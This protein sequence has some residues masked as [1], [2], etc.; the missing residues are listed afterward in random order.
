MIVNL[1]SSLPYLFL[2]VNVQ[3]KI[4]TT[5]YDLN[6]DPY[7]TENV[8]D[9]PAY[10]D[11]LVQI[12]SRV[13]YWW[14]LAAPSQ[15]PDDSN[16]DEMWKNRGG[17]GPWLE[18]GDIIK[19]SVEKRVALPGTDFPNIVFVML[20]DWGWNDL[21]MRST[22]L[23]WTTPN[24]DRIA[25]EGISL[26]NYFTH[27]TCIPSRG[28]FLTGKYPFR[29]GLSNF[30]ETELPIAET[31]IAEHL[32][33]LGYRTNLVGKWHMGFSSSALLP[34]NRGFDYFYGYHSDY[35]D[36]WTKSANG[37]ELYLDLQEGTSLVNSATEI[38]NNMH[39]GYL[40]QSKVEKVIAD[41]V[42]FYEDQPLFLFYSMPLMGGSWQAPQE[43]LARCAYP[44]NEY[45]QDDVIANHEY[46][47]CGLNVMIDE[48]IA[49]LTCAIESYGLANNTVMIIVSDNGGSEDVIGNNYP[50][51][52]SK[53][54]HYRGGVSSTAIIHSKL[55]PEERRGK[56]FDGLMHVT[57][58]SHVFLGCII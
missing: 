23:S 36:Q 21:G 18:D 7:E 42:T 15:I 28:A 34:T 45:I 5:L 47:Y 51:Q 52:G 19:P 54:D 12:N 35:I 14:K 10:S 53:G 32:Q 17:V 37:K 48:A 9:E 50:Y 31:T 55:V 39:A 26:T 58:I 49:N 29:L 6:I 2:I 4:K 24:I 20:D 43:F 22:Y 3:A 41:H 46:N 27:S 25:S 44:R 38:D 33:S 13:D 30:D 40:M 16:K 11:I 1:H 56:T 8:L 57:G